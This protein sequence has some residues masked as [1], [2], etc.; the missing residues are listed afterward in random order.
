VAVFASTLLAAAP[1][2]AGPAED[3][4]SFVTSIMDKFNGGDAKAFLAAHEHNAVIVDEFGRHLWTG[5]G[6]AKQWLDDYTK[7]SSADGI[8]NP[9]VDYGKPLQAN[10]DGNSAYVVLPT[11]YRWVQKGAKMA[12]PGSITFVVRRY[13][14]QWK[15]VSW[16]Y[17][18][19]AAAPEK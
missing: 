12:E 13:G 16:T 11:T 7:M 19:G 6:T 5:T 10:S 17:S 2:S 18:G 4:T 9:R 15:I 1:V 8:T 3:A 14:Q